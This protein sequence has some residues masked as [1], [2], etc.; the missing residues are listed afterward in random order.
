MIKR[1]SKLITSIALTTILFSTYGCSGMRTMTEPIDTPIGYDNRSSNDRYSGY[2]NQQSGLDTARSNISE[3]Q[4]NFVNGSYGSTSDISNSQIIREEIIGDEPP[5]E[6]RTKMIED[7]DMFSAKLGDVIKLVL[8]GI[9][10]SLVIEPNVNLN[11]PV[12]FKIYNKSIYETLKYVV[13]SSGNHLYYDQRRNSIIIS[14]Y[15]S[16]KYFIPPE[17]FVK[18]GANIQFGS[19]GGGIMPQFD[20][21]NA[22]TLTLLQ[23]GLKGIGSSEKI[24]NIDSQTGVVMVKERSPY[25]RDID[26]FL[27]DFV[28]ER[29]QQ[30]NVELAVIEYSKDKK[31]EIGM[32]IMDI[33]AK[34]FEISSIGGSR[35]SSITS[36]IE[37]GGAVI[38]MANNYVNTAS[39]IAR[40]SDFAFKTLLSAL[41]KTGSVDIVSK[42]NVLVQNHSIGYI[43]VGDTINYLKQ[44]RTETVTTNGTVVQTTTPEI[45]TYKD[46]LQFAVRVD[47]YK[48]GDRISISLAPMLSSTILKT[49]GEGSAAIQLPNTKRREAF[50][51]ATVKNGDIIVL[52]GMKN[53]KSSRDKTSSPFLNDDSFL[54]NLFGHKKKEE[55]ETEVM[56][57]V[58]VNQVFQSNEL[59]NIPSNRIRF[60][61]R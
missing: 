25:I 32:D 60:M 18:R 22:D 39:A 20:I 27:T 43:S 33:R 61:G 21:N 47:K 7:M 15:V 28:K 2:S 6:L 13:N 3:F 53:I 41:K 14:R 56:F 10:T 59:D 34:G 48:S 46:G 36:M 52:G 42:P 17:I 58:K 24:F 29:T 8:N 4:N 31:Q 5:Y 51:V 9:N 45:G 16:K 40:S 37:N 55:S 38:S 35:P 19:E 50:S 23:N 26:S 12:S 44:N 11:T 57:I 1:N 30:F 54:G 49:I